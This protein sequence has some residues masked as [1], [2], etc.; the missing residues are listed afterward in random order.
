M[1]VEDGKWEVLEA[2]RQNPLAFLL[3]TADMASTINWKGE[4]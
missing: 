2:H 1:G 3:H 4:E